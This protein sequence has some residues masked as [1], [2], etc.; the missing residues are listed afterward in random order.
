VLVNRSGLHEVP[1]WLS[2]VQCLPGVETVEIGGSS[3]LRLRGLEFARCTRGEV[4]FGLHTRR[5]A[6]EQDR[7]EIEGLA[8]EIGRL[9]SP[10]VPV[11]AGG[12]A[13]AVPERWLEGCV[14]AGLTTIDAGL[15][16][17]PVYG[18]A[19]TL[20][21]GERGV[22][23]LLAAG[24]DGRL[25]VVELKASEDVHLP[26]QALDYWARVKTHLEAG[27][28]ERCNYFRGLQISRRAP[29]LLLV[30][31]ALQF[32]P[33]TETILRFFSPAIDVERIGVAMNWRVSLKAVFRA[34]GSL[35][36]V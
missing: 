22:I 14:R 23:D 29:R 35:P 24:L 2:S 3:S 13:S 6:R 36:A 12:L 25:T 7:P 18:Q 33:T 19:P 34:R 15:L 11:S 10:E 26:L 8:R 20:S 9:R 5:L 4:R 31:P 27:D 16:P 1:A 30:A 21:A 17:E 28:F 32:H